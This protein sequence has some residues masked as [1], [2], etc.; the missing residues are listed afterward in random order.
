MWKSTAK[1]L[2]IALSMTTLGTG[3][4]IQ[5]LIDFLNVIQPP[6]PP[7]EDC[8]DL[9]DSCLDAGN[10]PEACFERYLE[11]EGEPPPPVDDCCSAA[12]TTPVWC[13]R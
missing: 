5:D 7:V 4:S 3:C 6:P 8:G 13:P 11:C 2:F 9:L 12:A 1:T 10:D